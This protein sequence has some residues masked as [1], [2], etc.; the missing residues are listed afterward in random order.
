[1][2]LVTVSKVNVYGHAKVILA[3][4]GSSV[5]TYFW[6]QTLSPHS[7]TRRRSAPAPSSSARTEAPPAASPLRLV[8]TKEDW[9]TGVQRKANRPWPVPVAGSQPSAAAFLLLEVGA[10]EGRHRHEVSRT[11]QGVGKIYSARPVAGASAQSNSLRRR[12]AATP[13]P[14]PGSG[15]A[16]ARRPARPL[17]A[18]SAADER[19]TSG[20]HRAP[21]ATAGAVTT[22]SP[23]DNSRR[24]IPRSLPPPSLLASEGYPLCDW[25]THR[26]L[27]SGFDPA[28]RPSRLDMT[29]RL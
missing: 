7:P 3:F 4:R 19:A 26:G 11:T 1:M 22:P 8:L 29:R 16:P 5:A 9:S 6:A 14:A 23:A 2:S 28:A 13:T 20:S 24:L 25:T 15:R 17:G 12:R 18:R 27:R 21:T 10:R